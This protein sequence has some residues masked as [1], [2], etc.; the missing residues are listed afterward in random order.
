M[1]PCVMAS[2]VLIRD[3]YLLL[4]ESFWEKKTS[5]VC[6]EAYKKFPAYLS[7]KW[8]QRIRALSW[9]SQLSFCVQK[10][11]IQNRTWPY[12][13]REAN[14]P[15]F[16]P[17]SK[18]RFIP[19]DGGQRITQITKWRGLELGPQTGDLHCGADPEKGFADLSHTVV[20]RVRIRAPQFLVCTSALR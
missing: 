8:R 17:R 6:L 11:L 20:G 10:Q 15:C 14:V 4:V 18:I 12:M 13:G 1:R 7:Y 3:L 5:F 9:L 2:A 19:K 16:P